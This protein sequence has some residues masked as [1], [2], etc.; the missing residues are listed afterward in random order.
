MKKLLKY[1]VG[2]GIGLSLLMAAPA[3]AQNLLRN[4]QFNN[5]FSS[6]TGRSGNVVQVG[7]SKGK[8]T[9]TVGGQLFQYNHAMTVGKEFEDV[10]HF[11]GTGN[12]GVYI[13]HDIPEVGGS[14]FVHFAVN[15][16]LTVT[17]VF[18]DLG[19]GVN[20]GSLFYLFSHTG[21]ISFAD[22]SQTAF[23]ASVPEVSPGSGAA[24]MALALGGLMLIGDRRRKEPK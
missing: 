15:G 4:P 10:F 7:V 24:P 9:N 19:F 3:G 18:T 12:V 14:N 16:K 17:N 8:Y 22:F 6:W 5:N 23:S 20:F 2:G 1:S 21:H 13:P 11:T